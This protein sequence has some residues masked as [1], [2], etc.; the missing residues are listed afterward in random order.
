VGR[1]SL[2]SVAALAAIAL[3]APTIALADDAPAP[4][5]APTPTAAPADAKPAD[6]K[7]ADAKPRDAKPGPTPPK[8]AVPDYDGRAP[9]P[10]TT[11]AK[12]AWIPRVILFPFR[13][14]ADFVLRRPIGWAI[15][16]AEHSKGFRRFIR[17]LFHEYE[18]GSPFIFPVVLVDFG[19]Q[20]SIGLRALWRNDFLR[21]GGSASVRVGTGGLDYW[22]ADGSTKQRFGPI[23][24]SAGIGANRR[25]DYVFY[26]VGYDTPPD[27]RARYSARKLVARAGISGHLEGLGELEVWGAGTDTSFRTST[28]GGESIEEQVAAGRIDELPD[29]YIGGYSTFRI[30]SSVTLDTRFDGRRAR[31]GARLDATIERVFDAEDSRQAW[32]R[33]E[34]QI[35]A[36]LLIDPVAERKVDVRLDLQF[37]EG[38]SGVDIPFLELATN[39]G[40]K[41]LGGMPPGRLYDRSAITLRMDYTWP[42]AAWLDARAHLAFGNVYDKGLRGLSL[43]TLRGST[44]L[45]VFIAGLAAERQVGIS[46]A[47][48]TEPLGDGLDF[49]G[50]RILLEY[51]SDY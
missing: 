13:L 15:S 12:L 9:A 26:G 47:F 46:A 39:A 51:S 16:R 24:I 36:G 49:S 45:G 35:G 34:L 11:G 41:L 5:P 29:A 8:R 6:A 28:W 30:G 22:R 1:R 33:F 25:P 43:S 14:V 3:A 4:T 2:L 20:P 50:S 32:T 18:H 10:S 17:S 48:G 7:P 31:S 19:F 37:V 42:L 40:T 23:A 21:K 38:D 27:A 44:G